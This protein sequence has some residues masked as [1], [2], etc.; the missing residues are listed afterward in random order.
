MK[1]KNYLWAIRE[2]FNVSFSS[3][4]TIVLF[5]VA[6]GL[7]NPIMINI[8]AKI[9]NKIEDYVA[10]YKTIFLVIVILSVAYIY[11]QTSS[12]FI[13]FFIEKVRIRLKVIFGRKLL[14]Q[15]TKFSIADLE[16]ENKYNMI[17]AVV[18]NADKQL[19]GMLL[20]FCIIIS[21]AIEFI[22]IFSI[23][24]RFNPL[25][26][27]IFILFACPLA[28]LSFK[29]GREVY[30]EDRGI[31]KLTRLM[32]YYTEVLSDK[33][34]INERTLFGYS[35]YIN[36]K[37]AEAHLKRS[38]ANT[39]VLAKWMMR[40][41]I[42]A[43]VLLIFSVYVILMMFE[44]ISRGTLTIGLFITLTGTIV[45]FSKQ[46]TQTFS[47][48]IFDIADQRE[49]L[50][51]IN[52]FFSIKGEEEYSE[53]TYNEEV[54]ETLQVI[55]LSFKYPNSE[56]YVLQNLNLTLEKGK[57]YSL[58]GINGAGKSTLIKILT[59]T[60]K[61]YDGIVLINGKDINTYSDNRLR[62]IFSLVFQDF[63]KYQISLKDNLIFSHEELWDTSVL[64]KSGLDD[65]IESLKEHEDTI[66]GKI[67]GN[68][69]DLSGGEWQKIVI[70]RALLRK[71]PFMIMDEPTASL[72][73]RV[74][75]DFYTNL[76]E[77]KKDSTLLLISHRMAATKITDEIILLDKGQIVEQGTHT[78]LMMQ[79]GLYY[80]MFE[81]QR[82]SYCDYE[83][84]QIY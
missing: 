72:S 37:Y 29:G 46:L 24:S 15:R 6:N 32:K 21:L 75:N 45:S 69:V 35:D 10:S 7:L 13:Q 83:E 26:I 47:R 36:G 49:Y 2:C 23:I 57:S 52:D 81:S 44:N 16:D 53:Y 18:N 38:N 19:S 33:E 41:K 71:V 67:E 11:R 79:R 22:G 77:M 1:K 58:I 59:G 39:I 63:A 12:I 40:I 51:E 17:E 28:V 65:L 43:V 31:I 55:D 50:V 62:N 56:Q 61:S 70:A 34:H 68:G 25:I 8:V 54:F 82:R 4:L 14:I 30:L 5:Y 64:H 78:D 60:Y 73:P 3:S 80:S 27:P 66:V 42:C 84:I 74:E 20:S 76:V 9:I 48:L